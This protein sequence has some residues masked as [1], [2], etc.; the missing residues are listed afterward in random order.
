MIYSGTCCRGGWHRVRSLLLLVAIGLFACDAQG[1]QAPFPVA[2]PESQDLDPAA[3]K[4]LAEVVHEFVEDEAA[5]G[6]ELLVIKNRKTVLH[7][8]FGWKNREAGEPMIKNTIFNIRSM[9]KPFTGAALQILIDRGLL[10]PDDPVS[11][12]LPAFDNERSRDI[13][14]AQVLTHRAGLHLS[15]LMKLGVALDHFESLQAMVNAVGEEGPEFEIGS[16]FWYSDSGTDVVGALVEVHSGML[17]NEFWEKEFFAPLGMHDTFVALDDRD[18]RY[19]RIASLY[20]GSANVWSRFWSPEQKPLYPFAWGS[21]TIYSTP[22]NYARF[23]AMWM[24]G[25][26]VG[27]QQLLSPEA[28]GRTLTP[29]SEMKMLGSDARFPTDYTGVEPWYGQMAQL[30]MPTDDPTGSAP[31]IIGHSGSDGTVALAWPA[32]DLMILYFTQSRGGTTVLTIEDSID[33]LLIHPDRV[34]VVEAVPEALKPYLGTY[35]AN[36]GPFREAEFEVLFKKGHLALDVP[37]Q[38]VFELDEPDAEGKR[39]FLMTDT[40]AV[41]FDETKDGAVTGLKMYQS[42]KTMELPRGRAKTIVDRPLDMKLV[43]RLV[44]TYVAKNDAKTVEVKVILN[45]GN[46]AFQ[47]PEVAFPLDL[48]TPDEDGFWVVRLDTKVKLHFDE[49][50]QGN[51]VSLTIRLPG[52][53]VEVFK[54]YAPE[55]DPPDEDSPNAEPDSAS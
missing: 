29:V 6:A 13:T 3:L 34:D 53:K 19:P 36:F 16:K 5:L 33:R 20:L 28:I 27:D 45:N 42:G 41:S 38:M 37:G 11:K 31:V 4:Q 49:D 32:K 24:D 52:G 23:L 39:Y 40:V 22:M 10:T 21:Q 17:L 14:V 35:V 8:V 47:P 12:Y 43:K 44:G 15:I 50:E 51:I 46:L 48:Y 18:P 55:N 9:S 25:G 7:E 2:T 26:R 54:R 30:W 1:Q